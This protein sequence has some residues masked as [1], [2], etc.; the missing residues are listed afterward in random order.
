LAVIL[1]VVGGDLYAKEPF[2]HCARNILLT[3][4]GDRLRI[5]SNTLGA[6][7]QAKQPQGNIDSNILGLLGA[8]TAVKCWLAASLDKTIRLQLDP[9]N[10][11]LIVEW[12]E[13]WM[14]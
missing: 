6:F 12:V 2:A 1:K 3:P 4:L 9:V 11:K 7:W 5:I 14:K 13:R 10:V 8:N